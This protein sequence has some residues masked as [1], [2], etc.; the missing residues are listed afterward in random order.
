MG[1]KARSPYKGWAKKP[2]DPK[3]VKVS[4]LIGR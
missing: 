1:R 4:K 3:V 2:L